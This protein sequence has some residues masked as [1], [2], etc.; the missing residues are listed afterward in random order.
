MIN[1]GVSSISSPEVTKQSRC[2]RSVR[3]LKPGCECREEHGMLNMLH[4]I[5][6]CWFEKIKLEPSLVK[7]I[8]MCAGGC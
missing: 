4:Y 2:R 7:L 3:A 6:F 5:V 8:L 1:Y